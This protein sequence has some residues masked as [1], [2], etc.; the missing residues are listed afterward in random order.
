[1]E[2]RKRVKYKKFRSWL[3]FHKQKKPAPSGLIITFGARGSGKSATIAKRY[4]KWLR[5][6]QSVYKGFYSNIEFTIPNPNSHYLDLENHKITDYFDPDDPAIKKYKVST[7]DFMNPVEFFISRDSIICLDELGIIANSRDYANFPKEFIHLIKILRKLGILMLAN[8]QNYDIDKQ[9]RLGAS[10]LRLQKKIVN[11]SYSRK[12]KKWID[13]SKDSNSAESQIVDQ[14]DFA[15][16]FE[17][18]AIQLTYIP[19]YAALYDS[20]A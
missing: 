4:L 1:M 3:N 9:L 5:K 16:I 8:S 18:D 17:K 15:N 11:L 14:V 12:I 6:E 10:D 7:Y 20:F 13:I 2:K 19:F